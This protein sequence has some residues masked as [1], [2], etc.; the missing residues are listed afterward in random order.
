MDVS[1]SM[2][3]ADVQ[4][5][6]LVAAQEAAKAFVAELPRNVKIARRLVRRHRRGRAGADAEPRRRQ[7]RDRPLPAAARH[8]DRQRHRALAG[9]DLSRGRHRPARRSPAQRRDAAA[10]PNDKPRARRSSR[11][12]P[13]SYASA[14]IILL[15]DG[16]RTT[17]PDSLEAAKMAADRGVRIYTVGIGTKEGETIGFEG[18]SMRVRLD[19]DT[20]K[21]IA[22]ADQRRL[23]LRRHR[24]G[25][26][27]GLP[28]PQHAAD[29]REEGNRDQR[30]ARRDRRGAGAARRGPLGL[31]VR[32]HR[33]GLRRNV[34]DVRREHLVT[35]LTR[36]KRSAPPEAT[37]SC[38]SRLCTG[39]GR[40]VDRSD[41]RD[42]VRSGLE[43]QV[44]SRKAES[45]EH[46][47]FVQVARRRHR[48]RQDGLLVAGLLHRLALG[49]RP[50]HL[51]AGRGRPASTTPARPS[52]TAPPTPTSRTA[53]VALAGLGFYAVYMLF[54]GVN[55]N[56]WLSD[57]LRRRGFTLIGEE[58]R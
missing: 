38:R 10:A 52:T 17:G 58:R 21:T 9:D 13:G 51:A 16:Q 31:V 29:R 47:S 20:L 41:R 35:E 50:A 4:P 34:R 57:S 22:N 44:S 6:R 39:S 40:G 48:P 43:T 30:A 32:A 19:E 1:G 15:T 42:A 2:R 12:A 54:C 53:G 56:R 37:Q 27:E 7:R 5:N 55:G 36:S 14:A 28:G 33:L 49:R 25:P 23:L 26:E 11:C 24:A 45:N 3:A 46:L 8:R 18:W